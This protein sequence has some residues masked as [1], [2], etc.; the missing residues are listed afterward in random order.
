MWPAKLPGED[1]RL[2]DACVAM[3]TLLRQLGVGVDG[4]KDSLSM[5][6]K[7]EGQVVK[8][9]GRTGLNWCY[10]TGKLYS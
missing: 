6:A 9:P 2:Y 5:A 1:A 10:N 3:T 7:V 8:S 4:G